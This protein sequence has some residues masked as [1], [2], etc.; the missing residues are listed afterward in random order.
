MAGADR[1]VGAGEDE[2]EAVLHGFGPRVHFIAAI[3]IIEWDNTK[4]G[5]QT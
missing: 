5:N 4:R 1:Q 2:R 3:A